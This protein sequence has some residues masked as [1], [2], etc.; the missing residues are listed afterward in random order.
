MHINHLLERADEAVFP[1]VGTSAKLG[2]IGYSGQK[3]VINLDSMNFDLP[4][5]EISFKTK[6]TTR[7]PEKLVNSC[8]MKT[9]II[10]SWS[11]ERS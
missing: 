7:C 10:Q 9:V 5:F 1:F 11:N 3:T 6:M 2:W 4:G 8:A